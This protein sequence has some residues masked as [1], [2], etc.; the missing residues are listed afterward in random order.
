MVTQAQNRPILN[1]YSTTL[2]GVDAD[3]IDF[4]IMPGL[5]YLSVLFSPAKAGAGD[6][7][8][9]SYVPY[10]SNSYSGTVFTAQAA[11]ATV[12]E[13]PTTDLDAIDLW[14]PLQFMRVR[15][16]LTGISTDTCTVTV[17]TVQK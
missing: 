5:E 2:Q 7:L 17:Y 16:I 9:F 1:S 10:I 8:S 15:Y 3:T 12:G 13:T 14:S 11:S 6:S 4:N